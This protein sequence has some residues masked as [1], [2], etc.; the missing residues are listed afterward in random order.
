MS[1]VMLVVVWC[2]AMLTTLMVGV[3]GEMMEA[4]TFTAPFNDVQVD[5]K[6]FVSKYVGETHAEGGEG[7]EG[8]RRR[9]EEAKREGPT[10]T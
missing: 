3:E 6:R 2:L 9:R 4:H 10:H 1:G 8:R 7:G 5:G